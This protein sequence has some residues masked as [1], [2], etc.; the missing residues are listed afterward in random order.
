MVFINFLSRTEI[1]WAYEDVMTNPL[2][3]DLLDSYETI[4]LQNIESGGAVN[5]WLVTYSVLVRPNSSQGIAIT[6]SGH[7]DEIIWLPVVYFQKQSYLPSLT[8]RYFGHSE[9]PHRKEVTAEGNAIEND[10]VALS[11][12][13]TLCINQLWKSIQACKTVPAQYPA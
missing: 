5:G 7:W 6:I 10:F 13:S 3:A 11:F 12:P 2:T 1:A 9:N 8:W 4:A